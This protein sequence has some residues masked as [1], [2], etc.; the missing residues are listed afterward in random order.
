MQHEYNR[1]IRP[2]AL[3]VRAALAIFYRGTLVLAFFALWGCFL[4][5]YCP[6]AVGATVY[7]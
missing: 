4:R 2:A 1:W 3:I 7:D 6:A 5:H